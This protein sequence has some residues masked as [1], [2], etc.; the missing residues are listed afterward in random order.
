MEELVAFLRDYGWQLSL[1]AL[2]GIV[3]LGVLKYCNVFSKLDETYR[4]IC[5]IAISAGVSIVGSIIYLACMH[6]L[7]VAYTFSVA[8]A[9]LT[10]NQ[11]FYAIYS[12]TPLKDLVK[13][14]LDWFKSLFSS[15]ELQDIVEDVVSGDIPEVKPTD[16]EKA[17]T[18]EEQAESS[19]ES[20]TKG[21]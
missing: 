19:E 1:I 11:A 4:H 9:I 20:S 10:L 3:I 2:L 7:T 12:A 16:T 18:Q 14:L 6:Q 13:K 21:N 17:T 15:G 5:Y 8:A